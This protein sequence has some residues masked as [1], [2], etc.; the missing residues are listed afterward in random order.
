MTE[1]GAILVAGGVAALIAFWGVLS[2]RAV[3]RRRTTLEFIARSEADRDLIA[4]RRQFIELAKASG[5]LVQWAEEDK[6]QTEQAQ[7]IR[8]V[9]NEFELVSI[10]IQRSIIDYKLYERWFKSGTIKYWN[11]AAPFVAALQGRLNNE[12]I[13]HEFKEMAGWFKDN[14]MPRRRIFWSKLF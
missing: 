2:H 9:L 11:Y 8:L 3:E 12:A 5:G 10:G 1:A 6:E 14:K 13:F 4:A 7:S